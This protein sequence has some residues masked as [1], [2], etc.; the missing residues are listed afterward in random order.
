MAYSNGQEG[1]ECEERR[2]L[3]GTYAFFVK[4][5]LILSTLP[6]GRYC[7]TKAETQTEK[8]HVLKAMGQGL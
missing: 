4:L 6:Q 8:G 3:V 2:W 7:S 5:H 1:R